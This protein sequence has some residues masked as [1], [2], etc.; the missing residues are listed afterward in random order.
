[1]KG[2]QNE[3]EAES[4]QND[5]HLSDEEDEEDEELMI[6]YGPI[7]QIV[8]NDLRSL[9]EMVSLDISQIRIGM[10]PSAMTVERTFG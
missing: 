3:L 2:Q 8:T 6:E 1:M 5:D 4:G 7:A 9:D 10:Q